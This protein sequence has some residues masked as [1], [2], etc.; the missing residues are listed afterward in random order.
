[1]RDQS[2]LSSLIAMNKRSKQIE[3]EGIELFQGIKSVKTDNLP[4]DLAVRFHEFRQKSAFHDQ[5]IAEHNERFR[6]DVSFL[7][8][9]S[10]EA[11]KAK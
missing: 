8:V 11:R 2:G 9:Q 7:H 4:V 3:K 6:N 1:M 10:T 5:Q